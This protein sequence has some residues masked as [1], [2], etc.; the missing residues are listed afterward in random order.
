M[1]LFKKDKEKF[2]APKGVQDIIPIKRIWKDGV[3][4]VGKNTY[5][6]TYRFTDINLSLIHI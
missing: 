3:F 6:K 4:L 2:I 1:K 5:S